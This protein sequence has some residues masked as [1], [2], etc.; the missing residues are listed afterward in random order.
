[1]ERTTIASYKR[2]KSYSPVY[3]TDQ[4][5]NHPHTQYKNIKIKSKLIALYAGKSTQKRKKNVC[6][7]LY[8]Q[9]N[10]LNTSRNLCA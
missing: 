1:M 7:Q 4:L 10:A 9:S 5:S 3:I 6:A 2:K 8:V